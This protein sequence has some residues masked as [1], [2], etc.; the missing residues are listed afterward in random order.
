MTQKKSIVIAGTLAGLILM[1]IL[2][3]SFTDISALI[4]RDQAQSL[5]PA[6]DVQSLDVNSQEDV[7]ALQDYA[8]ELESALQIMQDREA[9]YQEELNTAN[10]TITEMA[11]PAQSNFAYEDDDHDEYEEY[12]DDDHDEYEEHED[13]DH[14]EY[15]EHDDD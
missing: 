5:Q 4:P 12:E 13:D 9:Q 11:Q 15:E 3:F 6:T 2:A 8:T 1:T 10:H 14:D 7:Q